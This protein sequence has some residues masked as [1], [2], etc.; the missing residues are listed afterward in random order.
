M[1]AAPKPNSNF[2]HIFCTTSVSIIISAFFSAVAS[3]S[4]N[5]LAYLSTLSYTYSPLPTGSLR[6]GGACAAH[7]R[8]VNW[9]N[10]AARLRLAIVLREDL[11]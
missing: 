7:V 5:T 3:L 9:G 2:A 1:S 10:K 4:H 8:K 6:R 11:T